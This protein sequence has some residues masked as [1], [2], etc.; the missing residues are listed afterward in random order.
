MTNKIIIGRLEKVDLPIL[1]LYDLDAK[2]DTGAYTSSIHCQNIKVNTAKDEVEFKLLDSSH[3]AYHGKMLTFPISQIKRVKSSNG[4][5]QER[6]FIHVDIT[7]FGNSYEAELSLTDR[8]EMKHPMLIGRKFLNDK[9]IV[10]VS[11]TYQNS[12]R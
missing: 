5:V 8:Q 1:N 11:L 9:F 10:D 2:V 7:I 6:V 3:E 12:K 4:V